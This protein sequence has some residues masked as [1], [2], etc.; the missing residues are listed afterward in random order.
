MNQQDQYY[1]TASKVAEYI[2]YH[3]PSKV[4]SD[5]INACKNLDAIRQ[6]RDAIDA[7]EYEEQQRKE[8]EQR[9]AYAESIFEEM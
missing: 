7:M 6:L 2:D 4:L 8:F 9:Y 5:V 1:F 3:G